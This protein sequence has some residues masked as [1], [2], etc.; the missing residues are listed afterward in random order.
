MHRIAVAT[1]FST[2]SDRALRR[3]S[4]LARDARALL[5]LLHVVDDDQA[6]QLVQAAT[7]EATALLHEMSA[8]LK[9]V[10]G[11]DCAPHVLIGEPFEAIG[12]AVADLDAALL[13]IGPHRRQALNDIF[14][15]T[16]AER[17]IRR[18]DRPV[19]MANGVPAGPYGRILIATDFSDSSVR[20][21]SQVQRLGLLGRADVIVVHAFETVR[22]LTLRSSMTSDQLQAYIDEEREQANARL[23]DFFRQAELRE[24]RRIAVPAEESAART[25]L[26]QARTER[27]DL[28]VMGT[29]GRTGAGRLFLGSVAEDVLRRAEVDVLVVPP[30]T[31]T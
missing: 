28:I 20:A 23:G 17:T 9:E 10:E 27:A 19:L 24:G 31:G 16:T 2:R 3:A 18:I 7:R 29:Q 1:D 15:G 6:P 12:K 8:T 22:N 14:A 30:G 25:I 26:D 11:L 4:L 21:T 13:V 5:L